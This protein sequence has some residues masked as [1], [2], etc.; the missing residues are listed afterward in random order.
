MVETP[1]PSRDEIDRL[2]IDEESY[3]L[4]LRNLM[5]LHVQDRLVDREDYDTMSMAW[6]RLLNRMDVND[7]NEC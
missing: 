5:H 2:L 4:E 6:E 1:L 7:D 3:P